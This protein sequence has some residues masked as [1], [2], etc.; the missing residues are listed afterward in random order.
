[1]FGKMRKVSRI[2]GDDNGKS[3]LKGFKTGLHLSRII[4]RSHPLN[5]L[6]SRV[7]AEIKVARLK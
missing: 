1:M 4:S 5:K 6:D 2:R 3:V 7:Y